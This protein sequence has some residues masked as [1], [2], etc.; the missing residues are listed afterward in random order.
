LTTY[1]LLMKALLVRKIQYWMLK[2]SI[3]IFKVYS[4]LM[5]V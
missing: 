2:D 4:N 3:I 5:R 1:F